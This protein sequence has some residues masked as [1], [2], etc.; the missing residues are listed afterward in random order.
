[1]PSIKYI[2][3]IFAIIICS[4]TMEAKV[5]ITSFDVNTAIKASAQGSTVSR[6]NVIATSENEKLDVMGFWFVNSGVSYSD[7]I[8]V[9]RV[10]FNNFLF[11]SAQGDI[12]IDDINMLADVPAKLIGDPLFYPNPFR[13]SNLN[14]QTNEKGGALYYKLSKPMD[15]KIQMYNIFGQRIWKKDCP[16]NSSCGKVE[17]KIEFNKESLNGYEMSAGV[18]F[19]LFIYEGNVIGRGKVAVVP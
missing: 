16:A 13:F 15:I 8:V 12:G 19:Y 2:Y 11:D 6:S 14:N 3:G 9:M 10:A 7:D 18:Y 5:S 17:N 4:I 1:M